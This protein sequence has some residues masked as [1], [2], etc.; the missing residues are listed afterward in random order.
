MIDAKK[1]MIGVMSLA[2]ALELAARTKDD[3]ILLNPDVAPP[4][5]R[6]CAVSKFRYEQTKARKDAS[7]K[8]REARQDVKEL[9]LSPRTETHDLDVRDPAAL[10]ALAS[11][12]SFPA[13]RRVF[14]CC[15][16][17]TSK[18]PLIALLLLLAPAF[19]TAPASGALPVS[20]IA[21]LATL[22]A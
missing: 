4:L 20:R 21:S 12:G 3:V 7:K 18:G 9:K 2:D 14:W 5:V 16:T 6:L 19:R 1:E 10:S 8:Q 22:P 17:S 15:M 11:A 13:S